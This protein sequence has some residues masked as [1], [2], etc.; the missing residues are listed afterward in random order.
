[1]IHVENLTKYYND[2]CAVDQISFDISK[3]EIMGLLG[4]NGAGKTTTLQILTGFLR[5]TSGKIRVKDYSI[6]EDSL[7]IKKLLGYLPESAPLYHDMLV[8]D[9]LDYVANIRRLDSSKKI[10]RIRQLADLCGISEVM[11]KTINELSK[12]F[13][14][15]VGLAHAMMDDPEILV[16]DEPTSGL[17]PN[18]IIEIR[19]IIK[20]IGQEKTVILSTHIL[21]EAEATCDRIVIINKGKIVANDSTQILKQSAGGN[22]LI[23]LSLKNAEF[24]SVKQHLASISKISDIIKVSDNNDMLNLKLTCKSS[25]DIRGDIYKKVI[26]TDWILLEMHQ[27]TQTLENIFR[28]LTR[29]N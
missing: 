5:P 23:N 27:E 12:G 13:K 11:H 24:E 1:M 25:A 16:L 29:E 4:P 6:D 18:Q 17:D 21:S 15:R 20:Q 10:P 14:Q 2:L 19:D 8:H 26:Q 9:Y 22:K 3:G 28:E 7:Q